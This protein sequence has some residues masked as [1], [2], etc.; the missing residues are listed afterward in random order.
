M[1][2]GNI[3]Q[4]IDIQQTIGRGGGRRR[5]RLAAVALGLPLAAPVAA[6]ELPQRDAATHVG[7]GSCQTGPCH[8]AG[9][10]APGRVRQDEYIVWSSPRTP[11]SEAYRTLGTERSASIARYLGL[12]SAYDPVCLDCHA[13]NA[14]SRGAEHH[15]EDGVQ[16]EACHGGA[17]P[18]LK[19][20]AAPTRTHQQN[21]D[22][23]M[24]PT[25]RPVARANLCLSCHFGTPRKFVGHRML[26]AGH[27]RLRFELDT[28]GV[29]QPPHHQVDADYRERGK[30]APENARLWA[31]GQ[32]V[33][34]RSVLEVLADSSRYLDRGWPEFAVL[35]CYSCH[36]VIGERRRP[37]RTSTGLATQPGTPRLNDSSFLA[38]G[39][40]LRVVDPPAAERLR[41]DTLALHGAISRGAAEPAQ[42]A[43]AMLA[44]V[45][46][47]IDRL[48]EWEVGADAVRAIARGVVADGSARELRDYQAAEQAMQGVQ[49]LVQ[50][51]LELEPV[52]VTALQSAI[53]A[54]QQATLDENAFD[55]DAFAQALERLGAALR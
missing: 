54:L 44:R 27:P 46:R 18:W 5:A 23:G 53:D 9:G 51:L 42:L 15:L 47:S 20:H 43:R 38:L 17:E 11:H 7:V 33:Q 13:D 25:D 24:Y 52:D 10:E 3:Q 2:H 35:D 55:G 30:A 22:S 8:G 41:A 31:L 4:T 1:V 49:A 14:A 21:L 29:Y 37:P 32:A 45:D 26:G 34:V 48:E 16:C 50:T 40:V 12:D 19:S 39:Q 36:H 28:Y 6:Q